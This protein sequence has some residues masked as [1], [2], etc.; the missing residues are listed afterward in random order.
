ME[1]PSRQLIDDWIA[2]IL[3][4]GISAKVEAYF[5]ENP[6]ELPS[7]DPDA[8]LLQEAAK[9][10]PADPSMTAIMQALKAQA[11]GSL[12]DLPGSGWLDILT[13]TDKPGILGSLAQYEVIEVLATTGM[14]IVLKAYDPELK[15]TVALKILSPALATNGT[16]RQRFLREAKSMAKL[17]HPNIVPIYSIH[18][19]A[20]PW[21]AMRYIEGGSLEDAL[22][23]DAAGLRTPEFMESLASQ[24]GA[25]LEAAH[26]AGMVHRDIKPAN[27]LLDSA[28]DRMW[29]TDFGIARTAEDPGLT[30]G[31]SVPGTPRY[32]SP[33]Q[34]TGRQ[35]DARTDL[36]SLGSVLYHVATGQPPFTGSNSTAI[37]HK[38]SE[39]RPTHVTRL[40]PDL[41]GWLA[42]LVDGLLS[43]EPAE[44][45]AI[46]AALEEKKGKPA[47]F[48]LKWILPL[49][50]GLALVAGLLWFFGDEK[51]AP[52]AEVPG[53]AN[54]VLIEETGQRFSDLA[55]ALKEAPAEA[56]LI[57]KGRFL[58]EEPVVVKGGKRLEFKSTGETR[59]E[60]L[61]DHM[62]WGGITL[63]GDFRATGIDFIRETGPRACVLLS[64][65]GASTLE[66]KD[67]H[68]R[69]PIETPGAFV[70]GVEA[71]ACEDL[72]VSDCSFHG[73]RFYS[74]HLRESHDHP[75]PKAMTVELKK[76]HLQGS[77][78]I[79]LVLGETP[80][81]LKIMVS[82]CLMNGKRFLRFGAPTVLRQVDISIVDSVIDFQNELLLIEGKKMPELKAGLR[83]QGLRNFYGVRGYL[84]RMF[85][86]EET[87]NSLAQIREEFP[88]YNETES[89]R[90]A[91]FDVSGEL[92][93]TIVSPA[94]QVFQRLR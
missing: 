75:L 77:T 61:I 2:G 20:V 53:G 24:M 85:A 21:F 11:P 15:R 13:P 80:P 64:V 92:P 22:V 46:L 36:F 60:V 33:E 51:E 54:E 28:S 59:P 89:M 43:K 7:A 31:D 86:E 76:S 45:P 5:I 26:A 39:E 47:G 88:N 12:S 35:V 48:G 83:W 3:P 18:K 84:L 49:V 50:A 68:F 81:P 65:S 19:D 67:C 74:L 90:R 57:L 8:E 10:R 32:M 70:Y 72:R 62:E 94:V 40:N 44:R 87:F 37:L 25:A 79:Y 52:V 58:L 71:R 63:E 41:P 27:I 69:S 4:A 93:P 56:T 1:R 38:V 55:E 17:E 82:E 30:Y 16:A 29:L 66:V 91:L 42:D 14:G 78:G 73:P 23:K 6:E 34:A 9:G